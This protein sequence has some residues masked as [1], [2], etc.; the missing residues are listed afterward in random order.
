MDMK[1]LPPIDVLRQLLDYN[2]ETGILTWKAR[3]PKWFKADAI[4]TA[5]QVC[6][7]WN[8][9][10][11][12]KA[13]FTA[14]DSRG[15]RQGSINGVAYLANRVCWTMAHGT[16]PVGHVDHA[17]RDKGDNSKLNLRDATPSQNGYNG[18]PLPNATGRRG[19]KRVGQKWTASIRVLTKK[20]HLG[21]FDCPDKA[22]Q[23]YRDAAA[24]FHGE[25]RHR[26]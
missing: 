10:F 2:P 6:H 23:A 14:K 5:E 21:T 13:A 12:G 22:A 7:W 4:R 15:Y 11:A 3:D 1:P 18:A 25:F 8:A 19:V 16:P 9:R 20:H 26:V 17:N 24:R